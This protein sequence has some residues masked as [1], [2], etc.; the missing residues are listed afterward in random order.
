MRLF[1]PVLAFL[2]ALLLPNS[3]V[4]TW[5]GIVN[6][7]PRPLV[8]KGFVDE[9]LHTAVVLAKYA[10]NPKPRNVPRRLRQPGAYTQE[11]ILQFPQPAW[12]PSAGGLHA[13]AFVAQ[14]ESV[15][16]LFVTIRGTS[17]S[18]F[19]AFRLRST[20]NLPSTLVL[21]L[22]LTLT[23]T[24]LTNVSFQNLFLVARDLK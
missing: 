12:M 22:T 11:P 10:Y 23:L 16:T 18:D 14:E 7:E 24:L 3:A 13:Y 20:T 6:A 1:M 8:G 4:S 5:S 15:Q 2:V 9:W 21:T 19:G 17:F